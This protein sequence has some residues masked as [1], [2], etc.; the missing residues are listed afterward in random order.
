MSISRLTFGSTVEI[1]EFR[2]EIKERSGRFIF[3]KLNDDGEYI[4]LFSDSD[5]R[6]TSF[7]IF[8][9]DGFYTLGETFR[10]RRE[11][12]EKADG[13]IFIWKSRDLRIEQ[14]FTLYSDGYID[15]D[16]SVTNISS[17]SKSVGLKFVMDTGFE[18]EDHF[19]LK[20]GGIGIALNAEYEIDNALQ[21]EY[22]T[23]GALNKS[24]CALMYIP[25]DIN[26]SRQIF[27]NWDLLDDADNYYRTVEGRS[28]NNPPYSLNDSAVL[29][30][31]SP[32]DLL[33]QNILQYSFTFKA[34]SSVENHNEIEFT[35]D[36][37]P[38]PEKDEITDTSNVHLEQPEPVPAESQGQ[39]AV[40][41]I[42][43]EPVLEEPPETETGISEENQYEETKK[44]ENVKLEDSSESPDEQE[45]STDSQ[46]SDNQSD[47]VGSGLV[48]VEKIIDIIDTI[49]KP[50]II[51]ED[52]LSLLEDLIEELEKISADEN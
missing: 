15:I 44:D 19:F 6:T 22:W 4:S 37:L 7:S 38:L 14:R 39:E 31:Y 43:D 1:G 50:G 26:P 48:T 17:S 18:N 11:F 29:F 42:S 20:P 49:S 52:N 5:P 21:Y 23:S 16:F 32:N 10:Y 2:L 35:K 33:P 12:E 30:M 28:F 8:D 3:S 47:F 41:S 40:E 36:R 34:I 25:S 45:E 51:T 24:G 13:G 46:D 27:G 9:D